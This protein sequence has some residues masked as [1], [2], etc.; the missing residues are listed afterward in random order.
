MGWRQGMLTRH[1]HGIPLLHTVS[2]KEVLYLRALGFPL[3]F[4]W[5]FDASRT[6]Q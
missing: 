2:S 6:L 5:G 1:M 3:S 4:M